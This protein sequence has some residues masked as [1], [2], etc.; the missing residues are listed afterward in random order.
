[1]NSRT[2]EALQQRA[3]EVRARS[4]VRRWQYR[5]RHLAAG[6]WFRL[7]RVL[8]DAEQAFVIDEYD[9]RR[10]VEEGYAPEPCGSELAPAKTM[11]FVD[12]AR[13]AGLASRRRIP[14]TLGPELLTHPALALVPFDRR[15]IRR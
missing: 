7:R 15:R 4:L 8:A 3:R 12:E 10:L 6:V 11:V 13:L 1:M 9:A 5:Q 14:V 2:L